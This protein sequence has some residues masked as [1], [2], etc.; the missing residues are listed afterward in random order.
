M[1]KNSKNL[2]KGVGE[3]LYKSAHDVTPSLKRKVKT[4]SLAKAKKSVSIIKTNSLPKKPF[5]NKKK[6]TPA[7]T[8]E[9]TASK[10]KVS[11]K[12][13]TSI[14]LST[15]RTAPKKAGSP[16]KTTS[17]PSSLLVPALR[18]DALLARRVLRVFIEKYLKKT[19]WGWS[20]F[21]KLLPRSKVFKTRSQYIYLDLQ[22]KAL[23]HY[24]ISFFYTYEEFDPGSE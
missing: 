3:A 2:A 19:E 14:Q 4:D 10:K 5:L 8:T 1:N 11:P 24:A 9:N 22:Q 7:S 21:P 6:A 18:Q 13:T 20:A 16:K 12:K 23:R 17:I 15:K